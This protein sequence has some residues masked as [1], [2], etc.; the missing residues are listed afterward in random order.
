MPRLGQGH[1][2]IYLNKLIWYFIADIIFYVFIEY[3]ILD[4][5]LGIVF[6]F[7]SVPILYCNL[8]TF[9]QFSGIITT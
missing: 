9:E 2:Y 4:L 6:A 8:Y 1:Y 3:M 5:Y 7:L